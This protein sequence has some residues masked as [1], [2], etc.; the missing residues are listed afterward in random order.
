MA[1]RPV[2]TAGSTEEDGDGDI[3]ELQVLK[4]YDL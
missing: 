4:K 3:I 1:K 2:M